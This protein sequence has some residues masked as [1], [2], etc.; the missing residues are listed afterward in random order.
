MQILIVEDEPKIA[1]FIKKGLTEQ[2]Y[3]VDVAVN[4]QEALDKCSV[5]QYDLILLDLMLPL[6]DGLSVCRELR[7]LEIPTPILMVTAKD[8]V[9]SK[10]TGLD[11]GADD[12]L[13]KPFSFA[14]L[15]ARIRALLRREPSVKP[16][17]LEVADLKLNPATKMITRNSK[18][19]VLTAKEYALLEFFMRHPDQVLTKSE[20]IERVW[21]VN[22][23]GISNIVETYVKYVRQKLKTKPD[24]LDIIHTVRG[25][26]YILKST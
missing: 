15:T 21:D 24:D 17:I 1:A 19:I 10:V 20:I 5:N 22:Y 11:S 12:Y 16:V 26:G 6:V 25:S 8:A 4:G 13:T 2:R 14:E 9:E 7:T 18:E 3:T 23:D